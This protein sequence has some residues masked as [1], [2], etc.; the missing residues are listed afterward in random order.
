MINVDEI[1]IIQVVGYKNS[2]KTTCITHL[3]SALS[4]KGIKIATIKHHGHGGEPSEKQDTDTF[5]HKEAGA[6][7]TSVKGENSWVLSYT[8]DDHIELNDMISLYKKFPI[9]LIFVEGFKKAEY[10]KIVMLGGEED[11]GLL[12]ELT[13]VIAV[14]SLDKP[15]T[16]SKYFCFSIDKWSLYEEELLE[17][18]K[19]G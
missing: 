19:G 18:L 2:G 4:R 13:N 14:G 9:D 8:D 6:V 16:C 5:L 3:T 12:E 15:I 1:P 11:C 17:I 10:P 7:L